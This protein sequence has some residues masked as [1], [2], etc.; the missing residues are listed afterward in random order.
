[1]KGCA[2]GNMKKSAFI[3]ASLDGYIARF[4]GDIDWLS[5]VE[6]EG[7]DYGFK[8]FYNSIDMLV[9]GRNTYETVLKFNPWPYSEKRC[10]V[11]SSKKLTA[12]HNENFFS[13]TIPELHQYLE[14]KDAKSLYID[15]GRLIQGFL[16]NELLDEITVSVIPILLGSGIP[17]FGKLAKDKKLKLMECKN[18]ISGLVQ[19]RYSLK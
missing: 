13:G 18:F 6:L 8:D 11:Y 3:A 19:L 9:I 7:E 15:G 4:N 16:E 14:T 12:K 10:I 5:S 1:M 17:L 2:G